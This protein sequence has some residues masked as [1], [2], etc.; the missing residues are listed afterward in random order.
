[1]PP[2]AVWAVLAQET[3]PPAEVEGLEWMLLTTVAV[4][5]K[6]DAFERLAWYARRWGI[7]MCQTQPI[8]MTRCPLRHGFRTLP[9]LRG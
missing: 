5:H 1:M 2:V 9:Y 4:R 7:E 3:N 8:K 6:E